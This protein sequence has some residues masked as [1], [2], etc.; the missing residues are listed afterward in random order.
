ML[1]DESYKRPENFH[2]TNPNLGASVDMQFLLDEQAKAHEG[3]KEAIPGFYAKHLNVEIGLNLRSDRWA[4]ADYWLKRA[5]P[6]LTLAA[7]LERCEVAVAAIDGGGLDDLLALSVVGRERDTR[8]W[9]A[10]NMTWAHRSVLELRKSE[11]PRLLDFE[12]AGELILVDD[13]TEAFAQVAEQVAIVDASGLLHQ[14]GLDPMGV[15]LIVEALAEKS[16]SGDRVVAVSQGWKLSGAIKTAEV[17][18]ASGE[19]VHGGQAITAWAVGNAKVEPKGNAITITKQAAGT[20]KID[21][22]IALFTAVALM[23]LTPPASQSVFD[24]LAGAQS[25]A[26]EAQDD[27]IDQAILGNPQ[28]PRWQEMRERWERKHLSADEEV[29]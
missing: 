4:G 24:R 29:F 22:L 5:D 28:H 18:L 7:L 26:E 17:K 13:M 9:L 6:K 23:S 14:V 19:I 27:A 15:G 16:I 25:D 8:R 1:D 11:A 2:I 3:G 20:A 10:W 21:P 12:K